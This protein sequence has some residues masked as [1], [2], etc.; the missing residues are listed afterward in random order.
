M[1]ECIAAGIDDHYRGQT[2]KVWVK[3]R[4][5]ANVTEAIL[6]DFLKAQLS[7]IE[8]PK[9]FEIRDEPLPKT[10]IGKLS[11][12]AVLEEEKVKNID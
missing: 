6:K 1:E 9:L 4:E 10:L 11:R 5:G 8:I 12:K 3:R 2:V 7:A